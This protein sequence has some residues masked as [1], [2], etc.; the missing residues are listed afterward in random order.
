[1][2]KI[3]LKL[4]ASGISPQTGITHLIKTKDNWAKVDSNKIK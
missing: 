2:E 3:N 4:K 1:V